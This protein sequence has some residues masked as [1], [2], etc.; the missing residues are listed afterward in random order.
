MACLFLLTCSTLSQAQTS[1]VFASFVTWSP[2]GASLAVGDSTGEIQLWNM[3]TVELL[4]RIEAHQEYV[5]ALAWSRDGKYLASGSSDQT[6]KIWN[7]DGDELVHTLEG[8]GQGIA[9]M[10]WSEDSRQLYT[11]T[12]DPDYAPALRVWNAVTG[13]LVHSISGVAGGLVLSDDGG[14]LFLMRGTAV[15]ALNTQSFE[16]TGNFALPDDFDNNYK[17]TTRVSIASD[18]KQFAVGYINGWTRIWDL[19]SQQVVSELESHNLHPLCCNGAAD[20]KSEVTAVYFDGGIVTS[21]TQ[22]GTLRT[23]DVMKGNLIEDI[24]TVA[25]TRRTFFSPY[26]MRLV[27][28]NASSENATISTVQTLVPA[29]SLDKFQRLAQICRVSDTSDDMVETVSQIPDFI[30]QVEAL[31]EDEIPPACAADL[32]AVAVA[33]MA[34][35]E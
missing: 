4:T 11:G 9:S 16:T 20:S 13:E 2:D 21:V 26:G 3:E 5:T 30:A 10:V 25:T 24:Q 15:S 12:S 18:E 29:P 17:A 27:I 6:V 14:T 19:E 32:I 31:S 33:I 8:H 1:S 35:Q 7:L 28:L 22:D 23:W 34:G